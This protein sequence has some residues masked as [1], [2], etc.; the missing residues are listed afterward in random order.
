VRVLIVSAQLP[1]PP[2]FGFATRVYQLAKHLA[3][4]H[5][6]TL[7]SYA[8]PTERD[9]VAELALELPV[10]IVEREPRG[11]VSKR[12]A[13]A[14]S[15]AGVLPYCCRGILSRGMQ[16]EIHEAC[17]LMGIEVVQLEASYLCAFA[18]PPGVRVVLDEH[19]LE[20]EVFRRMSEGE[21]SLPRRAFNRL[22][23]ARFKRFEQRW[24]RR[25]DGCLVTSEREQQTVRKNAPQTPVAIVPNGVD[26]DHFR[27]APA[28]VHDRTVLFNGTLDYRPNV[29]AA[30]HLVEEVWPLVRRSCPSA[31]LVLVGRTDRET[32][33]R[34]SG[35]GVEVTGE[36]PDIRPY[37]ER[38]AVVTVPVR[39]GGGTRFKVLEAL[40][41]GKAVVSTTLGCEG[42]A[43]RDGEH[44]LIADDAAGFAARVLRLLERPAEREALGAAGR[45]LI[46]RGYSWELAGERMDALYNRLGHDVSAGLDL[47]GLSTIGRRAWG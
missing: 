13:Q 10:R 46:E 32:A 35:P 42:I 33:R 20:Y 19:N 40:A 12:L 24:W 8:R 27:P 11:G 44:L 34:L 21:R 3:A 30:H 17:T 28:G 22:E 36:V 5:E 41:M 18:Y 39:I 38:T 1:Y 14:R 15:L 37:L 47:A 7:L 23:H 6:V 25:V 2:R 29:D 4:Q 45:A 16:Q 26:I 43:V 31:R 9:A